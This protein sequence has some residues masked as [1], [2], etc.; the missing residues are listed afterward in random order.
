MFLEAEG[1][2]KKNHYLLR[3]IISL[4]L[5]VSIS[6]TAVTVSYAN[7]VQNQD[8]I[9]IQDDLLLEVKDKSKQ[10]VEVRE[11]AR[12]K[13]KDIK[14]D[15]VKEEIEINKEPKGK[16]EKSEEKDKIK[17]HIFFKHRY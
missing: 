14:D 11:E 6:T 9:E 12:D 1:S 7:Q 15:E 16:Q 8:T 3:G 5:T 10:D 4:A 13:K 2:L 17:E